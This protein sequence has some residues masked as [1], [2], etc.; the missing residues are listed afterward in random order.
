[1]DGL[2]K[3]TEG[4]ETGGQEIDLDITKKY[5][6]EI[7]SLKKNT[8]PVIE[9]QKLQNENKKLFESL[10]NNIEDESTDSE[11]QNT[12]IDD[13]RKSLF[14][15]DNLDNLEFWKKSL[16][17]RN[18]LIES[19]QQD[20]FLPVGHNVVPTQE[21]VDAANRVAE[22]IEQCIKYAK[23]D[24]VVFTNELQRIT[25]DNIPVRRIK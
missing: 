22:G 19:G 2:E 10:K 3:K 13:L 8:V 21:D 1:M 24:P 18:R 16:M 14:N 15:E 4:Q 23:G 9:Y 7:E 12:S 11:E 20:P 6:D 5:I 25:I 17:L